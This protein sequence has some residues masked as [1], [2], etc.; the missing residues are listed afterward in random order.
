[1]NC[2]YCSSQIPSG[3]N[4]C[5]V[6]GMPTFASSANS[7]S[8]QYDP[9]VV[10]SNPYGA[11]PASPTSIEPTVLASPP[12]APAQ[13]PATA[14]GANPYAQQ[15]PGTPVPPRDPYA[16]LFSPSPSPKPYS[17]PQVG[18]PAPYAPT[19]SAAGAPT[20]KQRR[21]PVGLSIL[22]LVLALLLIGGGG[23]IYYASASQSSLRQTQAT[24]TAGAQVTGTA[25][26]QATATVENP[27]TRSGTL[28][29]VDPLSDNSRGQNWDENINC[30]FK[31]GTYHAIAPDARFSDYC[32]ANT[33]NFSNFAFEVNMQI[34]KGD[35]GGVIFRVENTN[36]NQYYAFYVRQNG[37]Y[38]LDMVNGSGG[39]TLKQGWSAAI[40]QGLSQANLIGVVAQGNTMTLY[41]NHQEILSAIDGTYNHGEIGLY[42]VVYTQPTEVAFSDAR[43]WTF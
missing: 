33:T 27:Y 20:K 6:C 9:T 7:G 13:P 1:M 31:G 30:A 32:T 39:S 14:Y 21:F 37:S 4:V 28:A 15:N 36:P 43:V 22:L 12:G 3:A 26:A 18:P 17:T 5:P 19:F 16:D 11:P 42:A 8:S 2:R 41:V 24:A 34:I 29:F 40:K 23:L 10:A 38:S 25:H 35:A